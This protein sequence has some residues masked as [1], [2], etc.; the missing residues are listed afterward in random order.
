MPKR[1]AF[2]KDANHTSIKTAFEA[3]GAGVYDASNDNA[4]YDLVVFWRGRTIFV[5]VKDP[6]KPPSK[7][8]LTA[9][10]VQFH[11]TARRHGVKVEIVEHVAQAYALLG[12]RVTA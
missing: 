8:K 5:E 3:L 4:P 7:R 11:D 2:R 6:D 12:G 9:S 10:A 1:Y